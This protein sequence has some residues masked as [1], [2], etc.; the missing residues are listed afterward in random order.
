MLISL[1]EPK[2]KISPQYEGSLLVYAFILLF[3]LLKILE[4]NTPRFKKF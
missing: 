2:K 4:Y 1:L 3:M